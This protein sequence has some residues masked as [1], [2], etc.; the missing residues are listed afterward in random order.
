MSH[1]EFQHS[2]SIVKNTQEEIRELVRLQM[3]N[4][5]LKLIEGLFKEEVE[6]L[7]G[8]PFERKNGKCHRG[9]SETGSVVVQGQ[10]LSVKKPRVRDSKKEVPLESYSALQGFDLLCEKVM[11]HMLTGVSTRNYDPLLEELQS[12]LGLKKSSVSKAFKMGSR[13]ALEEIN[14]RDLSSYNFVSLMIDGTGFGGRLVISALGITDRGE[15]LN[16]GLREG[17]TENSEVCI[18]L[19]QSLIERGLRTDQPILFVIDGSKALRKS[20]RRVFGEKAPVQRCVRH[21]ERNILSYLPK[22]HHPEFRRR[23]KRLHGFAKLEE[24]EREYEKLQGW[25]GNINHEALN[26]LEEAGE[27]TLTLIKLNCPR[28]LRATLLST[29]PIE[30]AFSTVKAKTK[31]VKNWSSGNDQVS[32]WA[33]ATLLEAEKKFRTIKGFKE[34]RLLIEEMR[35]ISLEKK[36]EVA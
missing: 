19:L 8:S 9:G 35:K 25:L 2:L 32:R 22:Q 15:K 26:S 11:A 6:R 33:A 12:G 28:L 10:R 5:A 17:D 21:K 24:A 23:W 3:R 14:S 7:C 30:S 34:I 27:E 36:S 1:T 13:Q 31:R 18:D 29:N 16:I 4:S 20:I